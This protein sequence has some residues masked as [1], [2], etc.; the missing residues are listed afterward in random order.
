MEKCSKATSLNKNE[1][2]QSIKALHDLKIIHGDIKE[3][4]IMYSQVYK[5]NVLLAF[6]CSSVIAENVGEKTL[7]LFK[8]TH[9]KCYNEMK[10]L[11]MGKEPGEVDMYYND[12]VCW[13]SLNEKY[14][15]SMNW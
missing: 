4:N 3:D 15:N 7:T 5:K 6:N 9:T 13:E 10:R 12:I 2:L 11:Y 14:F 8:G 1:I